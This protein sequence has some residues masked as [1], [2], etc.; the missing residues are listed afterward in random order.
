MFEGYWPHVASDSN[1]PENARFIANELNQMTKVVFSTTL[2]E[3]TWANSV[4]FNLN[5]RRI[6]PRMENPP[7]G[8][9]TRTF[10]S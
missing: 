7:Q 3:V 6:I 1:A 4:L 10:A 9:R 2:Q 8:T 5:S